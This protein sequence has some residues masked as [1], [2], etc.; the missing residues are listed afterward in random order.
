MGEPGTNLLTYYVRSGEYAGTVFPVE[1][2]HYW[3]HDEWQEVL[4]PG[5]LDGL[6]Y[7]IHYFGTKSM[8][9]T[10]N[11]NGN[12]IWANY[13]ICGSAALAVPV[14]HGKGSES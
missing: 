14:S 3:H 10:N 9:E 2:F 8:K 12:S 13:S 5:H 6:N 4:C 1:Y 11:A 7:V